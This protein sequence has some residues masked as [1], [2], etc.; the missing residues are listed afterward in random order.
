MAS[1][2]GVS[3][4]DDGAKIPTPVAFSSRDCLI[5]V[6]RTTDPRVPL[7]WMIPSEDNV[8]GAHEVPTS[9]R[10]QAFAFC[11]DPRPDEV[12][13]NWINLEEA[14]GAVTR[15]ELEALPPAE[16]ILE[17]SSWATEPGHNGIA[18]DCVWPIQSPAQR[19]PFTCET[20]AAGIAWDTA[21]VPAGPYVIR[22][23]TYAPVNNL[24]SARAG[25]IRVGDT[26]AVARPPLAVLLDP[27]REAK[28]GADGPLSLRACLSDEAAAPV[29]LEWALASS[30]LVDEASWT[31][32]ATQSMDFA[33][34]GEVTFGAPPQ[35]TNQAIYVRASASSPASGEPWWSYGAA[36]ILVADSF[37][38][39]ATEDGSPTF[40]YCDHDE[41]E[42][43]GTS[44]GGC[45][46]QPGP[47]PA[48][49]LWLLF[50]S[51]GGRRQRRR[52]RR[53]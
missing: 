27:S 4:G 8:L 5:E 53:R 32:L 1:P 15:G 44:T 17:S 6:D 21:G 48:L 49:G 35:A 9:R 52:R 31:P 3:R 24:W 26:P 20:T 29:L 45:S 2:S 10:V 11:R 46:V 13:P 51:I 38:T 39:S 28:L 30:E 47:T 41:P 40:D 34:T 50:M 37:A 43:T 14:Q 25:V 18:G 36:P 7:Q 22:A 42:S 16:E 23:Y 19:T 12:L 33:E